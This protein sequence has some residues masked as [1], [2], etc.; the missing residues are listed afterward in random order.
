MYL[1]S[2]TYSAKA[3]FAAPGR[4]LSQYW[5]DSWR[6]SLPSSSPPVP[7]Y[8]DYPA[9]SSDR[10]FTQERFL[11]AAPSSRFHAFAGDPWSFSGCR[12]AA[13]SPDSERPLPAA[14]KRLPPVSVPEQKAEEIRHAGESSEV[15][16]GSES[17]QAGGD[18][19][20]PRSCAEE[21]CSQAP[22]ATEGQILLYLNYFLNCHLIFFKK[23]TS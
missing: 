4:R 16:P 10:I 1:P 18:A 22:H 20:L 8:P 15:R 7:V 13:F 5:D 12:P 3:D 11:H 21:E 17:P 2:C 23:H 14:A 9:A 6:W 19:P